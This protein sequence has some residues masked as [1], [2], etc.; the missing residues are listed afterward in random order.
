VAE[1]MIAKI[2]GL[3]EGQRQQFLRD[4]TGGR[5]DGTQPPR[6]A[7]GTGGGQNRP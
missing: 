3:P 2:Q 7:P 5:F 4:L 6:P 1:K